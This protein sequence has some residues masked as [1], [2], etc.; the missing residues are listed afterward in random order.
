VANA[1]GQSADH[2]DGFFHML[3]GELAFYIGCLNLHDRLAALGEGTCFPRPLAVGERR[4]RFRGLYDPCLALQMGRHVAGNTVDADGKRLVI[5]TGANQGG[6]SVF[7]RSLGV[8][9]LMMQCGMFVAAESFEGELSTGLVTHYK[10]EEDATLKSG[11]LDEELGR[12]S[13]I[14]DHLAPNAML[15]F[16]ESFAATN[17][18]EGS[19]IAR[20]VVSALVE[21]DMK[22]FFVTHLHAFSRGFFERGADGAL[23]LS[24]ERLSDGTRTFKLVEG[25]PLATSHAQ[26]LYERIF[27][28]DAGGGSAGIRSS[29]DP[30]SGEK[31][32][33]LRG[34]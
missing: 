15:L 34:A 3:R 21:K 20:Q 5:V 24:A 8:A 30:S 27:A 23:F 16:N 4:L 19:E 26:D 32:D 28:A 9:Q 22:V 18:R 31:R 10:R 13:A 25:E 29:A 7:L 33:A 14:V 17:E 6:K 1:L 2:V 11:K 12:M